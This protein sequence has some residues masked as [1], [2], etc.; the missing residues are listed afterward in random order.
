MI[1]FWHQLALPFSPASAISSANQQCPPT[2]LAPTVYL[3]WFW[4]RHTSCKILFLSFLFF[5]SIT[6]IPSFLYLSYSPWCYVWLRRTIEIWLCF[7]YL[8]LLFWCLS[9]SIF[10]W[11][12]LTRN[13]KPTLLLYHL[14][15]VTTAFILLCI[16]THTHRRIGGTSI[17]NQ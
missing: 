13:G 14:E 3:T 10:S 2:S 6:F 11:F 9:A 15:T 7:L 4:S 16:H 5:V 8:R 17:L 1:F 12:S